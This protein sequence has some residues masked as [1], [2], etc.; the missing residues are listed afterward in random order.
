MDQDYL[1]QTF[2]TG[3]TVPADGQYQLVGD[4]HNPVERIDDG[5][6]R[7][8]TTGDTLPPHPD[9]GAPAEWRFMR[10]AHNRE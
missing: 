1:G 8:F 7:Y 5:R 3:D 6:V 2:R 9:N 4:D 10:V